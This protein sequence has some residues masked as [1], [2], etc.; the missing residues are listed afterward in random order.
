MAEGSPRAVWNGVEVHFLQ[1]VRA[2]VFAIFDCCYASD[3]FRNVPETGRTYELLA[4]SHIGVTTSA[5]GEHSF[6][7]CLIK[8]LKD[9]AAQSAE[10]CFTTRDLQERLQKEREDESPALWRRIT[11]SNR[12]IRLKKGNHPDERSK[13][14]YAIPTS[15]RFLRLG[16]ALK[17]ELFTEMH[18]DRLTKKLP[19]LFQDAKV[20]V[21]DIRWLSCEKTGR[22]SF[23]KVAQHVLKHRREL[24][25]LYSLTTRRKRDA[26]EAGLC[27]VTTGAEDRQKHRKPRLLVTTPP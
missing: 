5:P 21:L 8:Q 20:P 7:R 6:T 18:I 25:E 24:T 10:G 15:A 2:D 1:T 22:P 13:K 19:K 26:D 23:K 4:A 14:G 9:L 16:F 17:N 27:D 3:L 11:G 12:H